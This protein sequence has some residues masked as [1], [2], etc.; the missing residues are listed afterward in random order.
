MYL[1]R[2]DGNPVSYVLTEQLRVVFRRKVRATGRTIGG[3]FREV[4]DAG[5]DETRLEICPAGQEG[6]SSYGHRAQRYWWYPRRRADDLKQVVRVVQDDDLDAIAAIDAEIEGY[7]KQIAEAR[8][9]RHQAVVRAW[10]RAEPMPL[11]DAVAMAETNQ[12]WATR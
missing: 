10:R 1:L 6:T 5:V 4:E 12:A 3:M 11:P 8:G 7:R 9:R 2:K